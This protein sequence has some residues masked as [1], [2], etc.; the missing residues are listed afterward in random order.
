MGKG[1]FA[2]MIIVPIVVGIVVY[3]VFGSSNLAFIVSFI[4]F[5]VL[6]AIIAGMQQETLEEKRNQP[7]S[8]ILARALQRNITVRCKSCGKQVAE[9]SYVCP[10]CG[11]ALPGLRIVCPK[12]SSSHIVLTRKGFSVGQAVAGGV[13]LGTIG[14]VAGAIGSL[15]NRLVCLGCNHKWSLPKPNTLASQQTNVISER[16]A[17]KPLLAQ[18]SRVKRL[19]APYVYREDIGKYRCEYC[20]QSGTYHYC[21]TLKGIERHIKDGHSAS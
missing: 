21:K 12:C 6:G 2:T 13:A 8:Q 20:L 11:E 7:S 14:L 4:L 10:S 9:L 5:G 16:K 15:D 17:G 18:H 19:N 3:N 1:A